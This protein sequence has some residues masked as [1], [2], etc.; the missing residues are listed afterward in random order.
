MSSTSKSEVTNMVNPRDQMQVPTL[1]YSL[2]SLHYTFSYL[3]LVLPSREWRIHDKPSILYRPSHLRHR[4]TKSHSPTFR[5]LNQ[6]LSVTASGSVPPRPS[7]S[8]P[9]GNTLLLRLLQPGA[10]PPLGVPEH[11]PGH[12]HLPPLRH[13]SRL[14]REG[15]GGA[16]LRKTTTT[17]TMRERLTGGTA[18]TRWTRALAWER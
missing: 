12:P 18:R 2:N 5:A 9:P 6:A 8:P 13:R 15:D 4:P 1:A 11:K 3:L 17:T 10:L 7:P 14:D 16:R